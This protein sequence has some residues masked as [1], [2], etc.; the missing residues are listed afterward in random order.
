MTKEIEIAADNAVKN[1][2]YFQSECLDEYL[3]GY[4]NGFIKGAQ[5]METIN[6][7]NKYPDVRPTEY[8]HYEVFRAGCDKQHY[9]TWNNTGWAYNNR[10]VTHW[11][12]KVRPDGTVM[13]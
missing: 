3:N 9:E 7:W 12:K 10:D 2:P 13:R 5:W 1:Y 11:R 8:G 6:P 4:G